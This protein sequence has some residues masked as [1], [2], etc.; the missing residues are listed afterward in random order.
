M[1]EEIVN[2]VAASGII[3]LELDR[4]HRQGDRVLLDLATRLENGF[5]LREKSFRE[6]IRTTD[7]SQYAGKFVAVCC[8]ADAIIPAWAY[9]LVGTALQPHA[10]MVVFGSLESLEERL[11]LEALNTEDW[12]RFRDARVVVKGCTSVEVPAAVYLDVAAR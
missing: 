12:N 3:T 1:A 7:W 10:A 11:F 4:Y 2:R 9:M 5:L 6:F 8:S